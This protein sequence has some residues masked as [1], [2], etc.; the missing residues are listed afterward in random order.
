MTSLPAALRECL[1]VVA[2][3]GCLEEEKRQYDPATRT[4]KILYRLLADGNLV[5]SVLMR[6]PYGWSVCLSTQVGCRMGCAFCASTLGGLVRNLTAGEIVDQAIALARDL[7]EESAS[8]TW[9]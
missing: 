1:A 9:C 3:P 8:A 2:H 5:E 6:Q 4:S 7:P